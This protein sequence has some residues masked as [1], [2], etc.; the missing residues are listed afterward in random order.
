VRRLSSC[1]NDNDD[2]EDDDDRPARR[3]AGKKKGKSKSGGQGAMV[4][5]LVGGGFGLVALLAIGI[6]MFRSGNNL[7]AP[8]QIPNTVVVPTIPTPTTPVPPQMA[9]TPETT[10]TN[11]RRQPHPQPPRIPT[12]SG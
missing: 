10:P 6:M 12:C 3:S 8:P 1:P 4:G 7:P 9:H 2:F 11:R 5:I